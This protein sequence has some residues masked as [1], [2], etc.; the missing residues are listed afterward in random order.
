MADLVRVYATADHFEGELMRGRLESEGVPVLLKGEGVGPYHVG[1]VYLFVAD[2]DEA[3]A[4][5]VLDAVASGAYA[6][7]ADDAFDVV[8]L[9]QT[10]PR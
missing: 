10:D 1:A 3:R 4:R 9:D 8:D 7:D 6:G 2:E 5:A